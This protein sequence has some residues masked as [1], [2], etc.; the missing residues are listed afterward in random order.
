MKNLT[1]SVYT[2]Q[3]LVE[4]DYLYVDKTDFIWQLLNPA[5]GVFF[6]SRPRRFGKSLTL[7]TLKA[8]FQNKKHLF[9]GLALE[10]K[11]YDWKEY[12]V[13]HLDLGSKEV[14][15]ADELKTY[16]WNRVDKVAR[17]CGIDLTLGSYDER[18][19]EL[20]ETLGETS[21]VVILIDE[22]DKPILD[23]LVRENLEAVRET[24][25]SFYSVVKATE[26]YQRFVLLTGVS[27][28]SKVSVFSKLNNLTDLS[29]DARFATMLGYTQ[30]ELER[31]FADRIEQVCQAQS[32]AREHLLDKIRRWYNGYKFHDKANTVYN[33]VSVGKFFDSGGE[34]RN[35]WFETGTPSFL[36]KL[37]KQQ[38]FDFEGELSRPVAELAFASY[39]VDKL[40]PLALLVQTGYLTIKSTTTVMERPR[41]FLDFPNMEVEGAFEAYLLDEYAKVDKQNV[42]ILSTDIAVLLNEGD[43]DG[44][45]EKMS[46]FFANIPYDI[47]VAN[48]KYYQT[49]FFIIFRLLGLFIEAESRTNIGRIDAVVQTETRV[50]LFE[51]KLDKTKEEALRQIRE[52]DY[53]RKFR[54]DPREIVLI[55]AAFS[56]KKRNIADWK[57][58]LA[59]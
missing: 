19:Q 47:Q 23:N 12:P 58:E 56:T 43:V 8:V 37:A 44:A 30:D 36:L 33:P 51:F 9:K 34:F 38:Q 24:L 49:I 5:K 32:L 31:C 20:I 41:Y 40:K 48:E 3:D 26:P 45:M 28:F 54:S 17:D 25:E 14:R 16:L 2:F 35:Y 7:S 6:L 10:N 50:Y 46:V 15:T 27:K 18:F 22:Y 53:Y 39:E 1:T 11:P 42:E 4:G 52:R 13:I 59:D 21:K 55:G 57:A 29:M